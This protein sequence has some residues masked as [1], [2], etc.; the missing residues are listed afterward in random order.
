M[1]T[2]HRT[3][4]L[5]FFTGALYSSTALAT[6]HSYQIDSAS[7]SGK[8]S[9]LLFNVAHSGAD[10][11]E[12]SGN[13]V[14]NP[15]DSTDDKITVHIPVGSI[16][17]HNALLN[18]QLKSESFFDQQNYPEALFESQ[19]VV[20]LTGDHYQIYGSLKIKGIVRQVML[21]ATLD[22]GNPAK[23]LASHQHIGFTA[24][25]SIHRSWY[26]MTQYRPMV[27]DVIDIA[28]AAQATER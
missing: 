22:Q 8:L 4:A 17:S 5:L 16:D 7:A 1:W 27:S 18:K 14:L 6:Q 25:T 28:I 13:I 20:K 12:V 3:T 11:A 21:N 26:A 15:E 9:W 24:S 23:M 19:R 2:L 10:F